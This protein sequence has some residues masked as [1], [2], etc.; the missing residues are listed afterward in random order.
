MTADPG[1]TRCDVTRDSRATPPVTIFLS[2]KIIRGT[3]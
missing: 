3:R 1:G 2:P